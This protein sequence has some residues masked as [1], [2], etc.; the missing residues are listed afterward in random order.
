MLV[1][2]DTLYWSVMLSVISVPNTLMT[3]TTDQ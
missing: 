1:T 2:S 3:T